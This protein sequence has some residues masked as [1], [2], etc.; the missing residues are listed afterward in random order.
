[1]T[2][3]DRVQFWWRSILIFL[4]HVAGFVAGIVGAAM[5]TAHWFPRGDEPGGFVLMGSLLI[6]LC[7]F[8]QWSVRRSLRAAGRSGD[9]PAGLATGRRSSTPIM[10]T[11]PVAKIVRHLK[12]A[13]EPKG[14]CLML[15]GFAVLIVGSGAGT[16]FGTYHILTMIVGAIVPGGSIAY[17][18]SVAG[19]LIASPVVMVALDR[20]C[21]RKT[22]NSVLELLIGSGW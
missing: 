11:L 2:A 1:M 22:N 15:I 21:V 19:A 20:W 9:A 14:G 17:N 16:A 7:L 4:V 12:T 13:P 6:L 3:P 8:L 18:F 5:I 10:P